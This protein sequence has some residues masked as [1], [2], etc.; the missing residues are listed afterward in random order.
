MNVEI[1][2]R[3]LWRVRKKG[4][5]YWEDKKKIMRDSDIAYK[6]I[7]MMIVT[8]R[9]KP[10]QALAE[11]DLMEQLGVGR[12]PI[13][14]ALNRLAWENFVKI[15]PRQ[16]IMVNE[17]SLQEVEA[18]YQMRFALAQLESELAVVNRTEEDLERIEK[19]IEALRSEVEPDKR[20]L[21]DREFH[22]AVSA[23]T[24]NPFLEKE[25]NNFQDLSIRLLFLNQVNLS[26]IDDMDIRTHENIYRHIKERDAEKLT[27]VQREHVKEFKNKFIW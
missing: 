8:A 25:M 5:Q 27:R 17:I 21:L 12:T 3:I 10:G 13:R 14:E 6:R 1:H 11:T 4:L 2:S 24:K 20:V 7:K 22:R 19:N 9:L 15:V 26:A 23:A 18:I 16:C